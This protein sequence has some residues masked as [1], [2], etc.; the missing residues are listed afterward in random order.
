MKL[1]D[2]RMPERIREV[3]IRFMA[4]KYPQYK[5]ELAEYVYTINYDNIG[6]KKKLQYQSPYSN[7]QLPIVVST[8]GNLYVDYSIDLNQYM[9]EKNITANPGEDIRELLVDAYPVVPAYSLPYT[10]NE[11]NEPIF[12]YDPIN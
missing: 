8:E 10:V 4:T 5:D 7:N 2:L 9:K 1:V 3:N 12:M 11:N 6:Y